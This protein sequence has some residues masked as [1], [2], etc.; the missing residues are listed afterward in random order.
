M[1]QII[2]KPLNG[3]AELVPDE[4]TVVA[5]DQA[6]PSEGKVLIA[7]DLWI[8]EK[9]FFRAR[10]ER[11]ELGVWLSPDCNPEL[12]AGDVNLLPIIAFDFPV[13]K[14]GQ[15]YSGAVLLRTRFGFK[16]QIRAF[17]D[18]WRDQLFYL[19]RCGFTQFHLKPGKSLDDALNG[20]NDFTTPYQT[21]ADNAL[22]I[23]SRRAA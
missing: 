18:I 17:G 1:N 4:F 23:F 15:G 8:A 13:F 9:D 2:H 16:G 12:L 6:V 19:A 14:Y 7:L 20:F 3:K 21:S 11:G 5:L 22:P 10:A